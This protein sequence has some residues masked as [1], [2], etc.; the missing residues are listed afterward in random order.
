MVPWDVFDPRIMGEIENFK[1][2][3][4]GTGPKALNHIV[5]AMLGSQALGDFSCAGFCWV[6]ILG[7]WLN[8][9]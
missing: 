9:G 3:E 8:S 5:K 4:G 7:S 6:E 2:R 1:S